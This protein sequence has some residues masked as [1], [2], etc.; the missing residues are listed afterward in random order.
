MALYEDHWGRR[1]R[2]PIIYFDVRKAG[3]IGPYFDH[4]AMEKVKII[5]EML[6]TTQSR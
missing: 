4:Q 6:K 3:V 2:Y 1:L 5:Q